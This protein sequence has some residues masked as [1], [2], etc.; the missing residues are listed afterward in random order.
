MSLLQKKD[1][2]A[3]ATAVRAAEARTSG[4]IVVVVVPRSDGY[5]GVRAGVA[6]LCALALTLVLWRVAPSLDRALVVVLELPVWLA[7]WVALGAPRLLSLI[8]PDHVE[9]AAVARG[10]AAAF[11]QHGV[12]R[13]TTRSGVLLYVSEQE[14]AVRIL[15]DS[16]VDEVLGEAVSRAI[17]DDV[18]AAVR[19]GRAGDA[20][21]AAIAKIGDALHARF[22]CEAD[23]GNELPEA[24]RSSG[25]ERTGPL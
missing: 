6:F 23:D 11:V 21:V 8:V 18:V 9:D 17:V 19:A 10:A 14:R 16:A 20:L 12:H 2:E 13:T 24:V 4:E 3:V 22:P 25:D 1:E 15:A 7:A 5:G